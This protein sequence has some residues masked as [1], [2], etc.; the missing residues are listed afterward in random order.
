M[1]CRVACTR[2]KTRFGEKPTVSCRWST[3]I[4]HKQK[5]M[6]DFHIISWLQKPRHPNQ[7]ISEM[8]KLLVT[9]ER[10]N[11]KT[12][13]INYNAFNVCRIK[14]HWDWEWRQFSRTM[15]QFICCTDEETEHDNGKISVFTS[16]LQNP[17]DSL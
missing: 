9:R 15:D 13:Q 2:L 10:K 11:G 8:E 1:G 6:M 5:L 14:R 7:Q 16:I 4:F 3:Y 12:I 17:L